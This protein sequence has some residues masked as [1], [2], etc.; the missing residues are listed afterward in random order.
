MTEVSS[1]IR[2]LHA[3]EIGL[4]AWQWGDQIFW[5]YGQTHTDKEI[6][7]LFD[8]SLNLGIRLWIPPRFT[9]RVIQ[10]GY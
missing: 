3:V 4:G 7:E 2:F 8:A 10:S 9:V 5:G 6:R 1:E